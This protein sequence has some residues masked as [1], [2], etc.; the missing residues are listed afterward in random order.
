[1]R[2]RSKGNGELVE[3]L[4]TVTL[5]VCLVTVAFKAPQIM[6][7]MADMITLSSAERTA[8]D[9]GGLITISGAAQDKITIYYEN[10]EETISYDI[11]IEDR[12][13]NIKNIRVY[14]ETVVSSETTV[15]KGWAKIG[16]GDVT[17][18]LIDVRDFVIEKDKEVDGKISDT[19][20]L[21][22]NG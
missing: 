17:L 14:G 3:I 8:L 18:N 11:E 5:S 2:G 13:L 20:D 7:E 19:Y 12:M 4:M 16:Y 1:M 10:E 22:E 21:K 9:L 6:G 15:S